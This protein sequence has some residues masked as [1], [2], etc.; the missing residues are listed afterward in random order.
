[1]TQRSAK[2]FE[3]KLF[4]KITNVFFQTRIDQTFNLVIEPSSES[5]STLASASAASFD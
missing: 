5:A 3:S 4:V 1:M 2:Q